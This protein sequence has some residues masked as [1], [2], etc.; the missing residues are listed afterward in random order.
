MKLV[1][2]EPGD[3]LGEPPRLRLQQEGKMAFYEKL[4]GLRSGGGEDKGAPSTALLRV[5]STGR[6]VQNPGA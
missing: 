3:Q 2:G 1:P 4:E 5:G 6:F